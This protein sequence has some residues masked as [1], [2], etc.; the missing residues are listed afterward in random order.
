MSFK[1]K[2]VEALLAA[3]GRRCC[4]CGTLHNVQ[5]HHIVPKEQGG[6]DQIDNAIPLCPS[7]HDRVHVKPS[8]GRTTRDYTAEELRLHRDRVIDQTRFIG[9]T[10]SVTSARLRVDAAAP[11][12]QPNLA[13]L[14]VDNISFT[15]DAE[16]DCATL[17]ISPERVV[18]FVTSEAQRHPL[19]FAAH[20]TSMPLLFGENVL[21]LTW[22]GVSARIERILHREEAYPLNDLW[23][24]CL[25]LYRKATLLPYRTEGTGQLTI[26]PH[27]KLALST[28][29]RLLEKTKDYARRLEGF[30]DVTV[31]NIS[32]L[33]H[34][35]DEAEF[36]FTSGDSGT[37]VARL[38]ALL[39]CIHKIL[40]RYAPQGRGTTSGQAFSPLNLEPADPE[41]RS[42][43]IVEDEKFMRR[44]VKELLESRGFQCY[45]APSSREAMRLLV[46]RDFD[47][48]ITD[49]MMPSKDSESDRV[50]G[51][52]LVLAAKNSG[53]RAKVVV[54]TGYKRMAVGSKVGG[55]KFPCD[56]FIV[57]PFSIPEFLGIVEG[58]HVGAEDKKAIKRR[59]RK[60]RD[61]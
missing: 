27:G 7:C 34:L 36:A 38:E 59:K 14:D 52:E 16:K 45:E 31:Q 35:L 37:C 20:F 40:L 42:V 18:V 33:Q 53:S 32:E 44:L 23:T 50:D 25:G 4:I 6:S 22:D 47:V 56:A 26:S 43:L 55:D 48:I 49:L 2:Q 30:A 8:R 24:S 17:E 13:A 28:F 41:K 11:Q 46:E 51:R 15:R 29:K 39:S 57:K 10:N 1:Q 19:I 5:V 60:K 61:G 21:L 3:V 58:S 12:S 54:M 9:G